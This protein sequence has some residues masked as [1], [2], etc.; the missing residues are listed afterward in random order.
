ML[1]TLL[2]CCFPSVPDREKLVDNQTVS[3]ITEKIGSV[4]T[5]WGRTVCDNESALI[6]SGQ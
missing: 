6:Y 1:L 3:A 4:Y 5:R 2:I